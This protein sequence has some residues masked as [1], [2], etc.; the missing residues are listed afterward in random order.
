MFGRLRS[1]PITFLGA[2]VVG[3]VDGYLHGY[4]PNNQY[5]PGLAR[6]RWRRTG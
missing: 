2:G 1:I 3:L 5:L 4:L 6:L